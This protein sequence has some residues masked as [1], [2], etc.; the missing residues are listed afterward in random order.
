MAD[1]GQYIRRSSL[2]PAQL[3]NNFQ[4]FSKRT[5]K[6]DIISIMGVEYKCVDGVAVINLASTTGEFP[7]GTK[8]EE[9]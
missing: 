2:P 4:L 7:W 1:N 9:Q 5:S 3:V 6:P 8:I